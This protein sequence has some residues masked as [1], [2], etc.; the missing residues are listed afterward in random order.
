MLE[1]TQAASECSTT[2][3]AAS[4]GRSRD[5]IAAI[6]PGLSILYSGIQIEINGHTTLLFVPTLAFTGDTK[7]YEKNS[8][9]G[10]PTRLRG[11]RKCLTKKKRK[12]D[13]ERS[14]DWKGKLKLTL[15]LQDSKIW[16]DG[17]WMVFPDTYVISRKEGLVHRLYVVVFLVFPPYCVFGSATFTFTLALSNIWYRLQNVQGTDCTLKREI[18]AIQETHQSRGECLTCYWWRSTLNSPWVPFQD[19]SDNVWY[20]N[21]PFINHSQDTAQ[22]MEEKRNWQQDKEN[23]KL[24][25]NHPEGIFSGLESVPKDLIDGIR[26]FVISSKSITSSERQWVVTSMI[27]GTWI[28]NSS[29]LPFFKHSGGIVASRY[30]IWLSIM[31]GHI[32]GMSKKSRI[33]F[34][35]R[36]LTI[37]SRI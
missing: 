9:S 6:E 24:F 22:T 10:P 18:R 7:Q 21:P 37:L 33:K 30:W 35:L 16:L 8:G 14:K 17:V 11:C 5:V 12:A 28:Y 31:H 36:G 3:T 4:W 29:R 25:G 26:S 23:S 20:E 27:Y 13:L 15:W 1:G 32:L 19:V 34:M 2:G